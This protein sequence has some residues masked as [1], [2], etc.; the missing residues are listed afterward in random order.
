MD[1]GQEIGRR[2]R[3]LFQ[4]GSLIDEEP[5]RHGQAAKRTAALIDA[6][7]PAIFEGAFEFDGIRIRVDV[8]ERL[9]SGTWG[10]REVKSSTRPKD[11]QYDDLAIQLHVLNGTGIALSSIELIHVNSAYVRG[12]TGISWPEFFTRVDVTDAVAPKLAELPAR[13]TEM[14]KC[15]NMAEL[16]DAEPGKQ[17]S[18]PYDCEFWDRCT[19]DKP[20]DWIAYLPRLSAARSSQLK[21]LGIDAISSIPLISL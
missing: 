12:P 11:C 1:V 16:P 7:V 18:T 13:L 19:A 15:L 14:R 6:R 4:G 20:A 17:C 5:W 8:L 3:L 10:L 2:G 9:A 21:A